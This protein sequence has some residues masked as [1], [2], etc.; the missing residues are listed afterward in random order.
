VSAREW[1]AADWLL[2]VQAVVGRMDRF[3]GLQ[4]L[5]LEELK[6][7]WQGLKA[8]HPRDFTVTP[9][10]AAAWHRLQAEHCLREGNGTGCFLHAWHGDGKLRALLGSPWLW[11]Q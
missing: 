2:L 3:G 4:A 6:S 7:G 1:T 9:G 8:K 10:Q 5:T 11:K